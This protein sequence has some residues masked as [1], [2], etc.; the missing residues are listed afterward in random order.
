MIPGLKKIDCAFGDQAN[1]SMF[2]GQATRP[3]SGEQ[4]LQ[5]FGLSD[6]GERLSKDRFDDVEKP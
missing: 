5:G 3:G 2:L 1:D 6:P 4:M